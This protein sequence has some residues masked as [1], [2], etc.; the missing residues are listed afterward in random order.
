M[1]SCALILCKRKQKN[2]VHPLSRDPN[3]ASTIPQQATQQKAIFQ[4][5]NLEFLNL[6]NG[7]GVSYFPAYKASKQAKSP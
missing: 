7:M 5:S 4:V 2:D 3:F 1:K 6:Q